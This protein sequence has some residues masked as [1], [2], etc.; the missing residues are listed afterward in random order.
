MN[1]LNRI[2]ASLT[3]AA[4]AA[5]AVA[6]LLVLSPLAEPAE[7]AV[8]AWLGAG[9][10]QLDTLTAPTRS[11]VVAGAGGALLLALTLLYLELTTLAKRPARLILRESGLGNVSVHVDGVRALASR[12]ATMVEGVREARTQ[13]RH[14]GDGLRLACHVAV[15]PSVDL[16]EL[17]RTVQ[18]RVRHAVQH[19]LGE[20][21]TEVSIEA[22]AASLSGRRFARIQ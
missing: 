20:A 18:E 13:L 11:W 9:L 19:H 15:D 16:P 12:E 6:I 2:V 10:V 5:A 7:F 3:L 21:V 14:D 22:Q 17:S 4:T 8:G 1:V